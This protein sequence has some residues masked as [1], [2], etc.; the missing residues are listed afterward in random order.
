MYHNRVGLRVCVCVCECGSQR[1]VYIISAVNSLMHVLLCLWPQSVPEEEEQ[2][3]AP[4][5]PL[6]CVL[7]AS[8]FFCL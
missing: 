6:D 4:P 8:S 2:Q 5:P 3:E 1:S 7:P